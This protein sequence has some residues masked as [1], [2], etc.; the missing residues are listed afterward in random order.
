[1][2]NNNL[3]VTKQK[4][5]FSFKTI[6]NW[7]KLNSGLIVPYLG[8]ALCLIVFA[9]VPPFTTGNSIFTHAFIRVYINKSVTL[10]ILTLGAIFIY[11]MG[12]MDISVGATAGVASIIM[13]SVS[14]ATG[15]NIVLGM[16]VAILFTIVCAFINASVGEFLHLPS[17]IGSIFLM[18]F[19]GGIQALYFKDRTS[20][21][22][23]GNY[24]FVSQTWFKFLVVFIFFVITVYLFKFTKLG[25]YTRAIGT[26]EQVARQSGINVWV[27]KI[28]AYSFLG[29]AVVIG[30][31]FSL[32][33]EGV[34]TKS[35]GNDYHMQIMIA[36][37]LGGMPLSGGMKSKVTAAI[38]GT[39][40]YNILDTGLALCGVPSEISAVVQ[41]LVL[42][43]IIVAT[44]RKKSTMLQ[45]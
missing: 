28:L 7:F 32:T 22:M 31:F 11:S 21:T 20:I 38:V 5:K 6:L 3:E 1:M 2:E 27:F 4:S 44:C 16:F 15:N 35:T 36:L 18:F 40:V 37:I 42:F 45:R 10:L 9:I 25:K 17:V 14:N 19:G 23:Y 34:V 24:D 39:L 13:V 41:A 12:S 43:I 26:N 8:L 29:I 33:R 30:S